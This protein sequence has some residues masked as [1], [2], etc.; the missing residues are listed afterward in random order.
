MQG[1]FVKTYGAGNS[2][3]LSADAQ[4]HSAPNRYKGKGSI[5]LIR[6][7]LKEDTMPG[8]ETVIRFDDKALT[9]LDN[10]FDAVKM[11]PSTTKTAI[12][13]KIGTTKYSINGQPF[14]DTFVEIPIL[15]N[16]ERS[17]DQI[18]KATRIDYLDN[19]T[20]TLK[21][22][23]TG[24]TADLRTSPEL[25]F[26]ADAPGTITD[27]FILKVSSITTGTENPVVLKNIFNVYTGNSNINIQT[28]SDE[29][30]GK[31]GSVR[32]MDLSG[33]TFNNLHD[34]EFR[35]GSLI[36]IG[37]PSAKGMYVVEITSGV[38]RYVGKV[39]IR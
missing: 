14:P 28:I 17:G 2:I 33:R 32:I 37:A 6:L 39:I 15:V 10:N 22:N 36:Q 4:V 1:F 24:F 5:P 7:S 25:S 11:F 3:T 8:D 38:K 27:R 16:L 21:D 26:F 19:Y 9:T 23:T 34:A 18:I 20:V 29:W 13:S 35:K 31:S 12:Y 30:E